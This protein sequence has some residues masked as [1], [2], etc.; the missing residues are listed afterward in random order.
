MEDCDHG[1]VTHNRS[2]HICD[3]V[4]HPDALRRISQSMDLRGCGIKLAVY[5]VVDDP[6]MAYHM[7]LAPA[8]IY[9]RAPNI[10]HKW[11]WIALGSI[12]EV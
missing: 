3:R 7:L 11:Q 5:L 9:Y 8:L 12:L 1:G 6:A 4:S 2:R 10:H